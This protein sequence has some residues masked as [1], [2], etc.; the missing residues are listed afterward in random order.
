MKK[1]IA[2]LVLTSLVLFALVGCNN[3]TSSTTT[4]ETTPTAS[5]K[6]QRPQELTEI[7]TTIENDVKEN[8]KTSFYINYEDLHFELKNSGHYDASDWVGE[9]FVVIVN[10]D[11]HYAQNESWYLQASQNNDKL[12]NEAFYNFFSLNGSFTNPIGMSREGLHIVYRS[13]DEFESDYSIIK[14]FVEF[15]YVKSISIGYQYALP[16]DYLIEN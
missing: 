16:G 3:G 14:S 13:L 8:N 9:H 15:Q 1:I 7:F 11:Y 12:L 6:H 5:P 2:V 10:C 4:E